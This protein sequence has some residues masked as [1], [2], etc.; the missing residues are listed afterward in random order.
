VKAL[1]TANVKVI[2]GNFKK[3]D[4]SCNNCS[5]SWVAHE[6]KETDVN[7]SIR[8]IDMT[9]KN[10][11]DRVLLITGDTDLAP[12]LRMVRQIAPT[13]QITIVLPQDVNLLV[14]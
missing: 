3:K 9:Y 8:L 6:E 5:S 11:F 7:I 1:K 14:A 13:K 10:S 12:A 2:L 4:R